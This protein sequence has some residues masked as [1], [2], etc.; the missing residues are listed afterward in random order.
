MWKRQP[1]NCTAAYPTRACNEV[2]PPSPGH[3][4]D[5]KTCECFVSSLTSGLLLGWQRWLSECS[6]RVRLWWAGLASWAL[7]PGQGWQ[8][9]K[10]L[11]PAPHTRRVCGKPW[12]SSAPEMGCFNWL[13]WHFRCVLLLSMALVNW[14]RSVKSP[15]HT[16][17]SIREEEEEM[18]L[19]VLVALVYWVGSAIFLKNTNRLCW[20]FTAT[21]RLHRHYTLWY[22]FK[23]AIIVAFGHSGSLGIFNPFSLSNYSLFLQTFAKGLGEDTIGKCE[24]MQLCK[25]HW[26]GALAGCKIHC[27]WQ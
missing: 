17:A 7:W 15:M 11:S 9:R 6:L 2:L 3:R 14:V 13:M 12:C 16:R 18:G 22:G 8:E 20:D 21:G 5:K 27:V 4:W 10:P 19:Q 26:C 24:L 1:P 25:A 23:T